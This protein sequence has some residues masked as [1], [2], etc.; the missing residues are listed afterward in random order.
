LERKEKEISFAIPSTKQAKEEGGDIAVKN[1]ERRS[2]PHMEQRITD[3]KAQEYP[4][5]KWQQ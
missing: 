3:Y 4:S 5:M 1:V 2:L